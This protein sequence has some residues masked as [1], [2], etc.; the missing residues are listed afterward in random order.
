MKKIHL[1]TLGL[2]AALLSS[3]QTPRTPTQN[4]RTLAQPP[5]PQTTAQPAQPH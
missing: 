3:T 2:L 5:P 1:S 4:A